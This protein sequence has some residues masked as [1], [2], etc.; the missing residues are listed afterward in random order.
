MSFGGNSL[1]NVLEGSTKKV[2][3]TLETSGQRAGAGREREGDGEE[4]EGEGEG[5]VSGGELKEKENFGV[6]V[7]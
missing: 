6:P 4:G 3:R 5:G 1:D 7:E 2:A